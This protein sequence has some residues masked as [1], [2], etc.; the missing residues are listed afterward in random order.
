MQDAGYTTAL[1]GKWHLGFYQRAY[2]PLERGFDFHLGY[3][4]GAIDYYSHKGGGYGGN[5]NEDAWFEGVFFFGWRSDNSSGGTSDQGFTPRGK[6]AELSMRGYA[7]RHGLNVTAVLQAA[8]SAVPL[9]PKTIFLLVTL[10]PLLKIARDRHRDEHEK[11]A[12]RGYR[13][14]LLQSRNEAL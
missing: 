13:R 8:P 10:C 12:I 9:P 5:D 11:P 7:A 1:F 2:T 6:P 4:Q 3:F 14:F